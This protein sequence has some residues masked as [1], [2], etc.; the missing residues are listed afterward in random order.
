MSTQTHQEFYLKKIKRRYVEIE[1]HIYLNLTPI[2]GVEIREAESFQ[3]YEDAINAPG[4][5]P[6]RIGERWGSGTRTGWFRLGF[7]VP[8]SFRGKP[9]CALLNLGHEGL[10]Y[11][12]GL[13]FQGIESI[14]HKEVLLSESAEP[15][16]R[17]DLVVEVM[18]NMAWFGRTEPAEF[19][20]AQIATIHREVESYWYSLGLLYELAEAL[21][22]SSVRRAKIIRGLNESV[23]AFDLDR[24]DEESLRR[25]AE[26]AAAI[27]QPLL[28]KKADASALRATC[29]GHSHID[30]AWLWPYA[31]SVRKCSRTFST[32]MRLME[33]YPDYHFSQSQP[34]LYEFTKERWPDLYRQIRERVKEGRWEAVGCMWVEA[35]TNVPSGESLVRQTLYGKRFFQEEFGVDTNILWLPDVFGYSGALPQILK[36][37]GVGYFQTNKILGNH[38]NTPPHHSFWWQGIDGTKVLAHLAPNGNYASLMSPSQLIPAQEW[39]TEKGCSDNILYQFGHGDGGGGAE[40]MHLENLKRAKDLEGLPK[41]VP[42]TAAQFFEKLAKEADA[43]ET[44]RGE[45][46]FEQHRGTYT[47]QS[48]TKKHN[49]KAEL[50]LR[51]AELLCTAAMTLGAQYPSEDL[52]KAWKIVLKNQFHDVLPG[53]SVPI[54]YEELEVDFAE[55]YRL[56][57]GATERAVE[58]VAAQTDTEGPGRPILVF[59]TLPWIRNGI[60]EITLPAYG[61]YLVLDSRGVEVLTQLSRDGKTLSFG[62][63]VP[64][65]GMEVYRLVNEAPL[66]GDGELTVSTGLLE[67][68]FFRIELDSDGLITSI[69]DK[70]AGRQVMPEGAKG[71]ALELFEDKPNKEPA[72]DIDFFY[73]EKGGPITALQSIEV[74]ELGPLFGSLRL[75]REFS[76][77]TLEQRIVIYSD[78]PRIDFITHVNWDEQDKM[79]KVAF[80]VDI[81]SPN[82]RYEIQFGNIERPTHK[83]TSVDFAKFEVSG[84]KWADLSES[85]YGVALMNDCKY[86]YNTDE[87]TIKLTLLR[88]P[89]TPGPENMCGSGPIADIGEHDFTYS[90]LPHQGEYHE[91]G[92]VRAGYELNVPLRT[93]LTTSHAGS[94]PSRTSLFTVVGESVVLDTVKKSED[95]GSIIL[96]LYEAH[97][98][99]VKASIA[100]ELLVTEAWECDLMENNIAKLDLR[101]GTVSF[102]MCP[103]EIK[104][105]RVIP[106]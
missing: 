51:D 100:T 48:R 106:A 1:S 20:M 41:L 92:V 76:G 56:V 14:W 42:G 87:N 52:H 68:K 64:S 79:L 78:N 29:V 90:L 33:Q 22:E 86:G 69:F 94:L 2:E 101:E 105:I 4:Y 39:Y 38:M 57:D 34:Q 91:G 102:E 47:T 17:Y 50:A 104:T 59:N 19:K 23:N 32:V 98:K 46:Y 84:H 53:S 8:E 66:P 93:V 83:S 60:A 36:K 25:S 77:S 15:G 62:T 71:N 67:N 73:T 80:P 58:Q 27:L 21:P 88:S 6:I 54:V 55:V 18:Y 40:R 26:R 31:E 82:A 37:A 81:N 95:D 12:D 44:W 7:A 99:R 89:S 75:V 28:E 72:W 74:D 16:K 5:R 13:P 11:K 85:D 30:T 61:E 3:N 35:D 96:R 9:F 24:T 49:R 43:F 10:V 103:F 45:L 97:N 63:R 70:Q 65:V